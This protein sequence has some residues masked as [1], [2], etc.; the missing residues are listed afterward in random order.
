[1]RNAIAAVLSVRSGLLKRQGDPP[2]TGSPISSSASET[3]GFSSITTSPAVLATTS[4]EVAVAT[5]NGFN[6]ANTS[7]SLATVTYTPLVV[8]VTGSSVDT[9][10]GILVSTSTD[11]NGAFTN[12]IFA[13]ASFA[14]TP[15][16][17][18]STVGALNTTSSTPPATSSN[19]TTSTGTAQSTATSSLSPTG[20]KS[21]DKSN[22]DLSKGA[23]AGIAVGC[24]I[25]GALITVGVL[26]FLMKDKLQK[27]HRSG[28]TSSRQ[29]GYSGSN[30]PGYLSGA[31]LR[32]PRSDR[33]KGRTV[34]QS[35][36]EA[37]VETILEQPKDDGSVKQSVAALFKAIEDHAEN[38]YVD[39]PARGVRTTKEPTTRA[40]H[41]PTGITAQNDVEFELL[42]ADR[43][44][45]SSAI[46][47]LITAHVL[48]AIDFF[49]ATE[50]SFLPQMVTSFLRSSAGQVKDNQSKLNASF[51]T[52][53][54]Y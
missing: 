52:R 46:T 18:V 28:T 3:A 14:Y 30:Q 22:G 44:S 26:F 29:P 38:Y 11:P 27:K 41:L 16:V 34:E 47:S 10:V 42:L 43:L 8:S 9:T 48:D 15:S 23:V 50:R 21:P 31:T 40:K 51:D 20:S 5:V 1:M 32:S 17:T 53:Y 49:G 33:D 13:P 6:G 7:F 4:V 36:E 12:T 39:T 35:V 25:I 24:A 54:N 45:R 37:T 2:P 19:V